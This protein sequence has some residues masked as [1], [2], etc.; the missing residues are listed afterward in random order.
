MG[1]GLEV[2]HRAPDHQ[3]N[4]GGREGGIVLDR[5]DVGVERPS[6]DERAASG[7][8]ACAKAPLVG[9]CGLRAGGVTRSGGVV[10][11]PGE[12]PRPRAGAHPLRADVGVAVRVLPRRGSG[13]G[14]R[15][16]H[17]PDAGP[18][19]PALRGC[20]CVQL[21]C[22]RLPRASP[23]LRRQRLRRDAAWPVRVGCQAVGC[24]PRGGGTGQR[25]HHEAMPEDEPGG[26]GELPRGDA[27]LRQPDDP[28]GLVCA[29]RRRRRRH[30]V[31]VRAQRSEAQEGQGRPQGDSSVGSRRPTPATAWR[32][33]TS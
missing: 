17:D 6:P 27:C 7:K 4:D 24:E 11:G 21:R 8:A 29:P 5:R 23:G 13:D 25:V 15:P 3:T 31:Q 26:R 18:E 22:V 16:R 19:S 2:C 28:R 32:R 14:R 30:G 20:A 33:S 9:A 1:T 10:D 12:D